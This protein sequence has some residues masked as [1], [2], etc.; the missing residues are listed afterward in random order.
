MKSKLKQAW[1]EISIEIEDLEEWLSELKKKIR[2]IECNIDYSHLLDV[3]VEGWLDS[4]PG[5][6]IPLYPAPY[7]SDGLDAIMET[8]ED[9]ADWQVAEFKY[10]FANDDEEELESGEAREAF[11]ETIA[12][13]VSMM[14]LCKTI[15]ELEK[16]LDK[17][18]AERKGIIRPHLAAYENAYDC[19]YYG[20]SY[21]FWREHNDYFENPEDAKF[22]W[23]L[24]FEKISNE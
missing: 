15:P 23:H 19:L 8:C 5:A 12:Y 4:V 16:Q 2:R 24:A 22:I 18:Y 17:M 7:P 14:S 10:H 20:N 21:S 11:L 6:E 1:D 3:I 13:N 9:I